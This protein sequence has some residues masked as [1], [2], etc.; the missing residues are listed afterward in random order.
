M[1][2]LGEHLSERRVHEKVLKTLVKSPDP[3]DPAW[4]RRCN[5]Q[6]ASV[7]TAIRSPSRRSCREND[8]PPIA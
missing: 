8:P 1:G 3:P 2:D 5:S 7:P 4:L 6:V